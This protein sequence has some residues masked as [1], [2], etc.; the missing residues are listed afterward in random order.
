MRNA[1]LFSV[2]FVFLQSSL[3]LYSQQSPQKHFDGQTWWE[4]VK[5]VADDRLEGRETGSEG[6]RKAE[7]YAVEQLVKAGVQPAGMDGFY[8]PVKFV[9]RQIMEKDS[10]IAL[11]RNGVEEPLVLGDDA[12]F[13]TRVDLVPEKLTAP[14][15]FAGYGL[16]IPERNYDDLGGLDLKGKI[17]VI[18]TGS[19]SDIPTALAAHYQWAGERWKTFR[20][21]A[22]NSP[23]K[24]P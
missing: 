17:A 14:L 3:C 15:V 24:V 9:S 11:L 21:A 19:P 13:N 7:A 10:S 18:L 16:K 6:L 5:F 20:K 12:F 23:S 4:H 8:Q 1:L 2:V 22:R